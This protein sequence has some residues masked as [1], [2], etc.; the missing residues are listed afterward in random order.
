MSY[1]FSKSSMLF[2]VTPYRPEKK[3]YLKCGSI[4]QVSIYSFWIWVKAIF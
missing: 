1:P 3:A 4:G 2:D